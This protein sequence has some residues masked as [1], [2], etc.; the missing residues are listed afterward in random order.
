MTMN[1]ISVVTALGL[2]GLLSVGA[3]PSIAGSNVVVVHSSR[4]RKLDRSIL[5]SFSDEAGIKVRF[6]EALGSNVI[7]KSKRHLHPPDVIILVGDD[8]R[9]KAV[10]ADLFYP[11][12]SLELDRL[13]QNG[14]R[15]KSGRW[16][17]LDPSNKYKS[18]AGIPKKAENKQNGIK[19]IKYL[20]KS[21]VDLLQGYVPSIHGSS[22]EEL[23]AFMNEGPK[24]KA[25]YKVPPSN[26]AP[27]PRVRESAVKVSQSSFHEKCKD[28]RDYQGCINSFS[29]NGS[30]SPGG[31]SEYERSMLELQRQELERQRNQD[32]LDQMRYGLEQ[33]E[34][35][36]EADRR[37]RQDRFRAVQG[38]LDDLNPPSVTCTSTP[39]YFGGSSTTCR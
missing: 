24:P 7:E 29:G 32:R 19:L 21:N 10:A 36:I 33:R 11:H 18:Y 4:L 28:A 8:H 23:T 9:Q 2:I 15:D 39:N 6:I 27:A 17:V 12:S 34:K 20:L 13:V 25:A 3:T 26:A 35:Q 14:Y 31:M 30:S 38:W 37:H 5:K 16:Y 22:V 1:S